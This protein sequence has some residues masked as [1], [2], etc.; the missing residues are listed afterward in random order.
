M[1][2]NIDRTLKA[3]LDLSPGSALLLYFIICVIHINAKLDVRRGDPGQLQSSA[4]TDNEYSVH[5]LEYV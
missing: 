1:T 4:D 5:Y 2:C 3:I